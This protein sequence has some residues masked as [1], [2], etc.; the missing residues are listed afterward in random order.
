MSWRKWLVRGLVFS[1]LGALAGAALLYQ[2]WTNPAAVRLQVMDRLN[3]MFPGATVSL[4]AAHLRLLGGISL[5]ELRLCRRD[6]P[7]QTDLIYVPSAIIYHDK[8]HFL[9]GKQAIRKVELFRPRLRLVRGS[10][11]GWN[12]ANLMAPANLE[13]TSP[14]LVVHQ[15][16]LIL[17]DQWAA[18][19]SPPLEIQDVNLTLLNDPLS[20]L[21]FQVNGHSE[22]TGT[23]QLNGTSQRPSGALAVTVQAP[24]VPLGGTCQERLELYCPKVAE[25]TRQLEGR[26][27]LQADLL[28]GPGKDLPW[29]YDVRA[30]LSQ[31]RLSHPQLPVSLDALAAELRYTDG[32]LTLEKLTAQAGT[33]IVSASGSAQAL[34]GD[35]DYGGQL[36]IQHLP[37]TP[38][39]LARLPGTLPRIK[40][41]F[42]PYGPVSLT[43]QIER[44]AG[45][46][47]R[48]CVVSAEDVTTSFVR[49]P[50]PLEHVTGSLEHHQEIQEGRENST[51][52]LDLAGTAN[53]QKVT[54][55]GSVIGDGPAAEVKIEIQ[56]KDLPIDD[57][58][59]AALPVQYQNLADQF[60]PTGRVSFIVSILREA[61]GHDFANYYKIRFDQA[62][63]RYAVFPYPLENVSGI[64]D[65]QPDHWEFYDFRGT[66]KGGEVR[67]RGK[68][69]P[70]STGDRLAIEVT[71]NNVLI[72]TEL[73]A[74]L[75]PELKR[76]WQMYHPSGRMN[77]LA[78]VDCP[79][80][81]PAEVEVT[82]E[83]MKCSIKPDCFPYAIREITGT[84]RYAQQ[85]IHLEK[86][87]ARHG[88]TVLSVDKGAVF[89]ESNGRVYTRLENLQANPLV[90]DEDF[91]RALPPA[92][93]KAC[94]ALE[95]KDPLALRTLLVIDAPAEAGR[96]PTVYWD[97]EVGL[98]D[99]ALN[100]GV[101]AEHVTGKA[102]A[103]GRFDGK[104]LVGLNGN[105]LF[106]EA[107]IFKQPFKEIQSSFSI[108]KETPTL[109]MMPGIH[110]RLFGGE[111]YG[112][113]R[114]ELG[115]P[116]RYEMTLTAAQVKL[117]EFGKHNLGANTPVSGLTGAQIYLKGQGTDP[118][119]LTGSGTVDVPKG[120][121]YNLPLLLDL[122]K[123]L[124][125]RP[126][127]GTAFEEAHATFTIR[128]NRM[129]LTRLDLVGNSV[130]LRGQGEMN[131][132]GSDINL[133]FYAVW[134][135]VVQMLPPIIKEIPP[136]ISQNL[137]K[138]KMRGKLGDTRCTK[139]PVPVLV[140]PVKELLDRM[141]GKKNR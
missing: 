104:V 109:L 49:F 10:D 130:S 76:A 82:V 101:P 68:P 71:G 42:A 18:P 133:D 44:K 9:N 43:V 59:H 33:A 96:L 108:A 127:D 63:V 50:Y 6:D 77:F 20:T 65:I 31:G 84:I 62:T 136:A 14:T 129:A 39:I 110:A 15:G 86:L 91:L 7:T 90:P 123:V 121:L 117:E 92:V 35:I 26:L 78:R 28:Y 93:L 132:D 4:D 21:V 94:Q 22:L 60:Q 69:Y 66:H 45:R 5:T 138:I 55:K 2:R 56:G 105:V 23:I 30:K 17:E 74:A 27:S 120:R 24:A 118:N 75:D 11:G 107:V 25:H 95:L 85:A 97:G 81:Q 8:E 58:L 54:F 3:S 137:L 83:P 38:P 140:E 115:P 48:H 13:E 106:Q 79:P 124:A 12:L 111:V 131:L 122:L 134:A 19:S 70:T 126:P 114:I 112:P 87:Q 135:R 89:L 100:L 64:L 80:N 102:A 57:K 1:V 29:T 73:E 67:T 99:A 36:A 72:D 46:S 51:L 61:G 40:D 32:H 47:T 34:E 37:L 125:L 141:A 52:Q 128:G 119:G 139:E 113:I 116:L 41:E 88:A 16:T 98:R 53:G 103:R